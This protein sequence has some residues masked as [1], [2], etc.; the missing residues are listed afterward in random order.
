[1]AAIVWK[2]VTALAPGLCD[3]DHAGQTAILAYVNQ[4]FN[5]DVLGGESSPTLRLC[6][7]YLAAHH[8][9]LT[10]SAVSASGGASAGPVTAEAA[11]GLSRSYGSTAAALADSAL[12]GTVY[13]QLL[14]QLL[15]GSCARAPLVT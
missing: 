10:G 9:L 2:D 8:A 7:I 14:V 4:A 13:G 5:V 15:R 3:L 12:S 6:R 1:M 11:G